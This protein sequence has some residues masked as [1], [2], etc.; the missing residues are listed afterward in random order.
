[1]DA[2]G[3]LESTMEEAQELLKVQLRATLAS[4]V[5]YKLPK[6]MNQFFYNMA[7]TTWAQKHVLFRIDHN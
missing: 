7:I 6:C 2:H 1:M 3:S 5:L 4:W